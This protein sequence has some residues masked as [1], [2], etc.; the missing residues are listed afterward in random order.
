MAQ[1]QPDRKLL[2]RLLHQVGRAIEEFALVEDGD[3]ILVGVSGGKDSFTLLYLLQRLRERAPVRF[4][5]VACNLDQG[6]PGFPAGKLEEYLRAQGCAVRML[7]ED[8]YSVVK[9][10]TPE[11]GTACAVCSR[12]R[13]GILYSAAAEM[14]CTK[15]ALGHHRDDLIESLLLSMLF[16][17]KIRSMPPKLRSDDGR[18]TVIRP[19]CFASEAD[20]AAF[21]ASAAFPI[22]PCDL[23]G[24]QEN[25]QRKRVKRLLSE[26]ESE[27]PGVRASLFASMGNL[28]PSHLLD[29]RLY[30]REAQSGRDPWIDGEDCAEPSPPLPLPLA[31]I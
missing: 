30:P 26:L 2:K 28:M 6:H 22:V 7:R 1:A 29:A 18:N 4:E 14:G 19:L 10:L 25:L 8:T 12:L 21:A 3:R 31:R 27:H 9:R 17:G 15:I 16:A 24:S 5:L 13:R 23:C 20:V 11:G